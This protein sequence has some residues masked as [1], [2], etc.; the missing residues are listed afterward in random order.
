MYEHFFNNSDLRRTSKATSRSEKIHQDNKEISD[1]EFL[2][3]ELAKEISK[4]ELKNKLKLSNNVSK[5]D[6]TN[7]NEKGHSMETGK[8]FCIPERFDTNISHQ[9]FDYTITFVNS[10]VDFVPNLIQKYIFQTNIYRVVQKKIY[11]V[12]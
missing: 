1:L 8:V 2:N 5:K 7:R 9:L 3:L 11:D 10:R 4:K 6:L 12:I